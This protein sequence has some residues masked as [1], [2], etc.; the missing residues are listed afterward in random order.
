MKISFNCQEK[1]IILIKSRKF[2]YKASIDYYY[3]KCSSSE[4]K[5]YISAKINNG[6]YARNL[7]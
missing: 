4:G 5:G 2:Y 3:Q 7:R 1:E 6:I